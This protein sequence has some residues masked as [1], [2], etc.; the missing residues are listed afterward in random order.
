M[1]KFLIFQILLASQVHSNETRIKIA[2]I[3]TGV[4]YETSKQSYMCEDG[5]I[6]MDPASLGYDTNG[7]GS[8]VSSAIGE[9]IDSTKFCII[10]Y[11]ILSGISTPQSLFKDRL[12]RVKDDIVKKH[13]KFV[14][15]SIQGGGYNSEEYKTI[16][17]I[18]KSVS[19]VSISA[20]N[21]KSNLDA[22]C[23]EF[24][25]CYNKVLKSKKI[26]VVGAYDTTYS[27]YGSFVK[28]KEIGHW[29]GMS[30]T[31]QAAALHTAKVAMGL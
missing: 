28:Y 2:V 8:N 18:V 16:I 20:G 9:N 30:G 31:S 22:K 7:H 14:N 5:N 1:F 15:M 26:H 12:N 27:N 4:D 25:A 13:V 19:V 11:Q 17:K 10:S 6:I 3:D 21:H 29:K 24:P 23:D